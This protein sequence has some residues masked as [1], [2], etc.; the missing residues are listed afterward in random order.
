MQLKGDIRPALQSPPPESRYARSFSGH[1][2]AVARRCHR[3][4]HHTN[5]PRFHSEE[6]SLPILVMSSTSGRT[7]LSN[8][9]P[10][11]MRRVRD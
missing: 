8:T 4:L 7:R 3:T 5:E 1:I 2:A 10:R 11:M 6:Y 9:S